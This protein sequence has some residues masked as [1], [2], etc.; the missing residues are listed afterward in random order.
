MVPSSISSSTSR[1]VKAIDL[2]R[3]KTV[4]LAPGGL[5]LML[6]NLQKPIAAGDVV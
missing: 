1:E 6:M 3:G 4:S 5:H 2:P